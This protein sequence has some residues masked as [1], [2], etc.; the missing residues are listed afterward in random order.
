MTVV[1]PTHEKGTLVRSPLPSEQRARTGGY[2]QEKR[3]VSGGLLGNTTAFSSQA[4]DCLRVAARN[5]R[6]CPD[7]KPDRS[8]QV[9]RGSDINPPASGFRGCVNR[10]RRFGQ[11]LLAER[12]LTVPF[13]PGARRALAP[14]KER[15]P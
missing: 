11:V 13:P 9:W 12:D 8:G 10:F 6:T 7:Q 4:L 15:G 1:T 5:D 3:V 14:G 2:F